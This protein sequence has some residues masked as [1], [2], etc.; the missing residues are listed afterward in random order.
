MR[1]ALYAPTRIFGMRLYGGVIAYEE[2]CVPICKF[3]A[4]KNVS[5]GFLLLTVAASTRPIPRMQESRH[6]RRPP[7][8]DALEAWKSL[9]KSRGFHDDLV[10]ILEENL[11]FEKDPTSEAGIKLGFQ[12]EFTPHPEGAAK[13]IYHHFAETDVRITFY[14]LGA[15]RNRSVCMLLCDDW[16]EPK[17]GKEGYTRKDDWL[18][19]FY[20]G[21]AEEIEEITDPNRW[22]DRVVRGRPLTAVDFC[23]TIE[24][25]REL[26]AHGRVLEPTERFG[27][28]II[29]SMQQK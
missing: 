5:G 15:S 18:I 3:V 6:Y 25:L 1:D 16:F 2:S 19:S 14:R 10:W 27:L 21:P 28:K 7:F 24:A 26:K 13:F 12:T 23:M 22:R 17:T 11:C 8:E 4:V 9:L 20:P 29:R